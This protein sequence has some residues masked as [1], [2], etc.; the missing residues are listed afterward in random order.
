MTREEIKKL[1]EKYYA[2]E[3]IKNLVFIEAAATNRT[4]QAHKEVLEK[5]IA[6]EAKYK[7]NK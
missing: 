2:P 3:K 6:L 4:I 7:K 5:L 1:T